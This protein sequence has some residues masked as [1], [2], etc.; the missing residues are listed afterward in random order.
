[1]NNGDTAAEVA[2]PKKQ[3]QSAPAPELWRDQSSRQSYST[4][5]SLMWKARS[6]EVKSTSEQLIRELYTWL[7]KSVGK[8]LL[9]A[10]R[11]DEH[12]P[13]IAVSKKKPRAQ[14]SR[15]D[16]AETL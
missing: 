16:G 15:V 1:M 13:G 3:Q 5:W 2:S 14:V 11:G 7:W 8:Q 6:S 9:Y 4:F 12:I 10:A